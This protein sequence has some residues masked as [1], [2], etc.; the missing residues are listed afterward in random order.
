MISLDMHFGEN[1]GM[2]IEDGGE[3][4]AWNLEV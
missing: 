3:G 4:I 2:W 1:S